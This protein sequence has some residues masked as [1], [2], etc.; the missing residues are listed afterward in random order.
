[1]IFN[2]TMPSNSGGG[3]GLAE[4]TSRDTG[5]D[6]NYVTV[7]LPNNLTCADLAE[8]FNNNTIKAVCLLGVTIDDIGEVLPSVPLFV[9]NID[10]FGAS[11]YGTVYC[12]FPSDDVDFSVVVNVTD[13][14][15]EQYDISNVDGITVIM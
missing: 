3:G 6:G 15:G 7:Y 8:G 5:N 1:M 9:T 13:F 4:Y 2:T 12:M 14:N 10:A 11:I